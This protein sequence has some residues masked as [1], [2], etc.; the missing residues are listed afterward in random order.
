MSAVMGREYT[1]EELNHIG[2]RIAHLIRAIWVRDG[3]TTYKDDFWGNEVDAMWQSIY[4][5]TDGQGHHYVPKEE[6]E[7]T[8]QMYYE[9]RGWVDGVPTRAT[10]EAFNMKDVADD[11]EARGLLKG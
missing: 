4:D 11:L 8:L 2:A 10:L 3:Y 9:E 1:L 5:R 6:Y 7:K